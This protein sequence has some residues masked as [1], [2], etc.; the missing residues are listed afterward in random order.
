MVGAGA[1]GRPPRPPAGGAAGCHP[2][3]ARRVVLGV[4]GGIAA[5][6]SIQLAR[7]LTAL[8]ATVDVVMTRSAAAFVGALS[9]E[10]LTGRR[11]LHEILA[12]GDALAHIRLARDA[13][14]VCVA[15]ATADF[16]AR[17][18]G[19]R[20]DDLLAAIV[21]AT[22]APVLVCPA[23]NDAMWEHAQ[24]QANVARLR[25]LGYRIVG[26]ATGRL[27]HGEGVGPGRME[28]PAV[29]L[30]HIG[31]ALGEEPR[32]RG[33]R[34]LV[35]AGPTREPVDDVRVLTNRSSGRMGFAIAQAAWRR[36]AD[37]TLIAG[38]TTAP[39]PT[40]PE[41]QR[42]ATAADMLAALQAALPAADLLV[43]AAAVAD[44][45]PVPAPGKLRRADAPAA[46]AV[47]PAPDLLLASRDARRPGAVMV[48]FALETG[49]GRASA[50]TKLEQKGLDFVV[51][52]RADEP[53]AGFDTE[54]N[55]VVL[56]DRSGA[57]ESLPLMSKADVADAL[58][59]RIGA[60]L[61]PPA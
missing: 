54:T 40:G 37:V 39:P 43:M 28:E 45:R 1:S 6:K 58:L 36:G 48:G 55:R 34:V 27:A 11:V 8:G 3:A 46:L 24:T 35:T 18:A 59:D 2:W 25:E 31:R 20:A 15:P 60:R 29:L 10:A 17:A 16:I 52:N 23:M 51:L 4:T 61:E 57:E 30:E 42:V 53:D 32:W 14:V 41:L 13:D 7:D 21:L 38:P 50:R 5:Y 19:G 26:P 33:R 49:D 9:F 47:E 12:E 44:F 22:R 56:L